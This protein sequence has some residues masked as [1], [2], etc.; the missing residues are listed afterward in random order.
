MCVRAWFLI[1]QNSFRLISCFLATIDVNLIIARRFGCPSSHYLR[2]RVYRKRT[3]PSMIPQNT[4][5]KTEYKCAAIRFIFADPGDRT[6]QRLGQRLLVCSNGSMDVFLLWVWYAVKQ[7]CLRRA[8]P[9]SR[10]VLINVCV[11]VCVINCHQVQQQ[12]ATPKVIGRGRH[13]I[14][15][16]PYIFNRLY[17]CHLNISETQTES[18]TAV[19]SVLITLNDVAKNRVWRM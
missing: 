2:I 8:D 3:F 11:C 9:F 18:C 6:V 15:W 14:I 7:K 16:R 4:C 13:T 1:F 19:R 10:G 17:T 12:P 5:H